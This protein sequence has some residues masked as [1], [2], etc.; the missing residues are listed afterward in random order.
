M[1]NQI[2]IGSLEIDAFKVGSADCKVYLGNTLLYPTTF[3]G[4]W[5]ATYQD[6]HVES[7]Q[8]DSSSAITQNEINRTNLVSVE[9]GDCVSS[10]GNSVFLNCSSLTSIDIPDTVTSIG[11]GTFNGCSGLTSIDIPY[12]VTSIG[13]TAFYRCSSLTSIDIPDTVTSIGNSTF[14]SCSGLRSIYIP[15][16]VT[17]I[18]S[19]AFYGCSSLTSID[20]PDSV[21]S[22]GNSAFASCISL[23]SCTIGNG[24]TSIDDDTFGSCI[25]LT[26]IYIPNGVTSIGNS[27]FARC[28]SL[29]S[30]TI[31]ATTPPT[32]GSGAFNSTNNC[33]IIV[34]CESVNDYKSASGWSDYASRITCIPSCNDLVLP[35]G[36][37][38][39]AYTTDKS[40]QIPYGGISSNYITVGECGKGYLKFN[41]IDSNYIYLDIA[42]SPKDGDED[43]ITIQINGDKCAAIYV[44]FVDN[45]EKISTGTDM[46]QY[47]GRSIKRIVINDTTIPSNFTRCMINDLNSP[48]YID[49]SQW[50]VNSRGDFSGIYSLPIDSTPTH[51]VRLEKWEYTD[52]S[53]QQSTINPFNDLRIEW[54]Y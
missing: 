8:C 49:I 23:T 28:R 18:G 31:E 48:S 32:L 7:A 47:Y 37:Y 44:G 54:E 12:S 46:A 33:P 14:G 6:S 45:S 34:P 39:T 9:I 42:N 22:I 41:S 5:L 16:G 50:A 11:S 43:C 13:V 38:F 25:S 27:A 35:D 52:G 51:T 19:S 20:I 4:K 3:Q 29:T 26:S 24:V 17:S 21:T 36:D 40:I 1:A 10:I 30:I 53:Y 2:K 15:N